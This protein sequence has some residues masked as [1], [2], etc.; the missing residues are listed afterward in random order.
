MSAAYFCFSFQAI[1]ATIYEEAVK[2]NDAFKQL[3]LAG[4]DGA[5]A[6][7]PSL[8]GCECCSTSA[9]RV[10]F[11]PIGY[12]SLSRLK[13]NGSTVLRRLLLRVGMLQI[14]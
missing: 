4:T 5:G 3:H 7:S 12:E 1:T 14:P 10:S 11:L 8:S 6:V 2:E 13:T 9:A